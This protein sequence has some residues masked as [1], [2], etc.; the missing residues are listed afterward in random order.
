[1]TR[2]ADDRTAWAAALDCLSEALE[3]DPRKLPKSVVHN[4]YYAMHHAARAVLLRAEQRAPMKH[5][6]VI[7]A[8]G[9]L[10]E[11][12]EDEALKLA[13]R[14]INE[15]EEMRLDSD[16]SGR[17]PDADEAARAADLSRRFLAL[18]AD[19]FEFDLP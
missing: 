1:M 18:C 13:G 17:R 14:N 11:G 3:A 15:V 19:R 12:R 6:Q 8:F 5:G 2:I 16:Y 7:G 10:A 9:R 4:A